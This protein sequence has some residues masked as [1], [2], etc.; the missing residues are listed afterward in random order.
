[1][2]ITTD[3][4]YKVLALDID[5]T[6]A[7]NDRTISDNTR[8]T[9]LQAQQQGTRIVIASGRP[10]FGIRPLADELQLA[11]YGG[12]V[13]AYNGA[14]IYDWQSGEALYQKPLSKDIIP[15]I[16]DKCS[17]AGLDVMTYCG[18]EIITESASNQYIQLSSKRNGMKIRSVSS[19]LEGIDYPIFKCMIVGEPSQL[20]QFE[21][22]LNSYLSG[23]A[24]AYRSESFYLE[25]V[26]LGID[27][28]SCLEVILSHL[29]LTADS[30]I[31]CGD[32]YN[33]IS[34]IRFA[35]LGVAMENANEQV[36]KSADYITLSNEA[37]G[38]AAVV[39]KFIL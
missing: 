6:L 17:T 13:L 24:I 18:S 15:V 16:Y 2:I 29:S 32:G 21:P 36:K 11:Q 30:L 35:G 19:F 28:A 9:L 38:V 10:A 8:Q 12:F 22:L 31:A 23:K 37:D 14:E 25:V 27:K 3:S 4:K 20:A 1:M 5:G 7:R 33:D 39:R 34:M 26:P